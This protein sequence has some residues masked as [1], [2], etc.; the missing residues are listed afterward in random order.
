MTDTVDQKQQPTSKPGTPNATAQDKDEGGFWDTF[1][2]VWDAAGKAVKRGRKAAGKAVKETADVLQGDEK[3]SIK[4]AGYVSDKNKDIFNNMVNKGH[5]YG[6]NTVKYGGKALK[7]NAS[8]LYSVGFSVGMGT[9][10]IG[11][12]VAPEVSKQLSKRFSAK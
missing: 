11:D 6:K 1:G 12:V 9:S 5:E 4:F 2:E 8:P 3:N 10:L 7:T